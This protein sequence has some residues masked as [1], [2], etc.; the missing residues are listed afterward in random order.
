MV[1]QIK[2]IGLT[3]LKNG[4]HFTFASL[5]LENA[6]AD[7][8]VMNQAKALIESLAAS[9]KKE[10]DA[11][12]LS[13]KNLV[14]DEITAAD[15]N[16]GKA[17]MAYKKAVEAFSALP[18]SDLAKTAKVLKQHVKDYN[19]K[20][21]DQMDQETGL[22]MNLLA[23]LEGKY[24]TQVAALSLTPFVEKMKEA[25]EQV[26]TLTVQRT[27]ERATQ[28]VGALK[29]ART[30]TDEAY[31]KLVQVVNALV[32]LNGEDDFAKFI[33]Y[34][35]TQIVHYKRQALGTKTSATTTT[36]PSTPSTDGDG[37]STED[38]GGTSEGDGST[39]EGSGSSGSGTD[40]GTGGSGSSSSTESGGNTGGDSGSS[41]GGNNDGS[42]V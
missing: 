19:I 7:E 24:K 6:Q 25:N 27:N 16:R 1:K 4:A 39:S 34:V 12:K 26:K 2:S 3:A 21:D 35:N 15:E 32:V 38:K 31:R 9:V 11:L 33:D 37:D 18:S 40:E 28:Q 17:Y 20:T 30:A 10:D 22:M 23:D 41:S 42:L 36:Q 29:T 14:T 13:R 8:K 5:I